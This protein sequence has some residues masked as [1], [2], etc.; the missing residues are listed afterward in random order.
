MKLRTL[1]QFLLVISLTACG[2]ITISFPTSTSQPS[3]E[4]PD[5]VI[6]SVYLGMQ[7]IPGIPGCVPAYAPFEIKAIVENRGT[8]PAA[9]VLVIEQ[10]TQHQIQ[11]GTL[12]ALQS[13]EVQ[14]PLS[15]TGSYTVVVDPQNT[16]AESNENNNVY[17]YIA[18][19]PTPPAIC[20]PA[21]AT[22]AP[23]LLP[24]TPT[25]ASLDGLFYAEMGI[26]KIFKVSSGGTPIQLM[27]GLTV[28]VSPNGLQDLFERSGDLWLA[29]PMDNPGVNLTNTSDRLEQM[30]Q[31][32]PAN[33][34]KVVFNSMGTHEGQEKSW[35]HDISGYASIMNKDG[36]EYTT[37]SD[38]PS[39]TRPALSS[40]GKTIAYDSLGVPM[41]YEIGAASRPLD[42][43][44]YGFQTEIP[45]AV[46]TSPSF[47]P[48]GHQLTWWV[49][50]G[51][52]ESPR[53]FSLVRFDLTRQ[54]TVTLHSYTAPAGILSW[55]D[56][57]IWSP[58]GQWI[59]AQT[60]SEVSPWDLWIFSRDGTVSQRFGLGANPVWSPDGQRLAYAQWTQTQPADTYLDPNIFTIEVPSW[61]TQQ[62]SLPA[63]AF[64][65]AWITAPQ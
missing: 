29:E 7:G 47:S 25:S 39:Y 50:E 24:N 26:G 17:S 14:F 21:Q 48:D 11:V 56:S 54:T 43:S 9:G 8:I 52:S 62:S 41:L 6:S 38:I 61:N 35:S 15:P 4:L 2:P 10:S 49:S 46:F 28:Q 30:P 20:T 13:T 42:V 65:L 32:W 27:D 60:R 31:W 12:Q 51:P 18:P 1:F 58:G 36:S 57:P 33:P 55:L 59:A 45:N 3:A 23:T 34:A 22:P 5:L 37:L 44:Q 64:P 53:H 16:V 40:D 19:T 63:G